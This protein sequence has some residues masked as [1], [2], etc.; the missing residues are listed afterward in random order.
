MYLKCYCDRELEVSHFFTVSVQVK[1]SC[2]LTHADY[3]VGLMEPLC[4]FHK[5]V[6]S[7][8]ILHAT[9]HLM[10]IL[11]PETRVWSFLMYVRCTHTTVSY[12]LL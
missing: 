6:W 3:C 4:S 10:L 11:L 1:I 5:S 12:G 2:S 8:T 7:F 9:I